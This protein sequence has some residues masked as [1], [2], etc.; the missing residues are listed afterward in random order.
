MELIYS[1][2]GVVK[3]RSY[4]NLNEFMKI[5]KPSQEND[6]DIFS[7]V[8]MGVGSVSYTDFSVALSNELDLRILPKN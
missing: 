6:E 2:A 5:V 7:A 4:Q 1:E 3:V 8:L